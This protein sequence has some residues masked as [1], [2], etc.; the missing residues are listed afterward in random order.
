MKNKI[1]DKIKSEE[2]WEDVIAFLTVIGVIWGII[3]FIKQL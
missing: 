3:W 1:L 2:F